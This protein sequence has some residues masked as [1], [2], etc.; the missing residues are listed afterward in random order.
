MRA[1]EIEERV[2][3]L[4]NNL[5]PLEDIVAELRHAS[6]APSPDAAGAARLI[7][8]DSGLCA[9]LLSLANRPPFR[10]AGDPAVETIGQALTRVGVS[11]LASSAAA[12]RSIEDGVRPPRG[13]WGDY[14]RHSREIS[15]ICAILSEG[16]GHPRAEV[17]MFT[18]A[19]L[20]H[21]VGRVVMFVAARND[22]APLLGTQPEKMA[23]VVV[24]ERTAYGLDHCRIGFELFRRWN[25]S[26]TMQQAILRHHTPLVVDD[27]CFAGGLIF[28]SHFVTMSDFTG[29]IISGFLPPELLR[30]LGLSPGD[31][32]RAREACFRRT[33]RE[34]HGS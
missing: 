14:L 10:G 29:E 3:A 11:S 20:T 34:G 26:E 21:D 4:V 17:E 23:Q 28:V 31:L 25:F 24:D 30:R 27:F 19:G 7:G 32:D 6:A 8:D 1:G 33:A 13:Q 2:A 18:A 16:L 9:T 15:G 22:T 5:P 12:M